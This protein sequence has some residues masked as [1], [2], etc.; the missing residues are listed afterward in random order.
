MSS[1]TANDARMALPEDFS[2]QRSVGLLLD[3]VQVEPL[4][5]RLFE[6]SPLPALEVLY[7]GTLD[8][9]KTLSPCLVRLTDPKD[10]ILAQFL[11]NLD[12]RWGYLLISDAPWPDVVAH[13]RW[14]TVVEH[15]SG[16]EL[17]LRIAYPETAKALFGPTSSDWAL[18]GPC[19]HLLIADPAEGSWRQYSRFGEMPEPNHAAPYRLS[20][21]QWASLDSASADK[22]LNELVRHMQ[23]HFP[24]F[25]AELTQPQRR[26]H[27]RALADRAAELGF[28]SEQELYLFANAHGFMNLPSL[29]DPQS[30]ALLTQPN[31]ST[32]AEA[33]AAAAQKRSQP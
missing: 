4:L 10:P 33:I 23:Q 15:P 24:D 32:T 11:A 13:L 3:A 18:F 21:Q 2:W 14:L 5:Q 20:E 1:A 12:Q 8:E 6:W 26:E 9:F 25:R 16:Q 27:L 30:I 17:L 31:P 19:Q 29:L 22:R 28:H 7:V